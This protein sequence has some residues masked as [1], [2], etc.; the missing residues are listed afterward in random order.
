MTPRPVALGLAL[1]DH[2]IVERGTDKV[3]LIGQFSTIRLAAFPGVPLPF[4][5][6]CSLTGSAG[7]GTVRLEVVE[8]ESLAI[9]QEIDRPI[10]LRDRL[11]E[12][13][14]I[15]R[16]SECR[17]PH[18]GSYDFQLLVDGEWIAQ[19]R[20]RVIEGLKGETA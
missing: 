12:L 9:V 10:R 5:V 11:E 13:R 14:R 20:I 19:R 18:P 16:L 1:C 4:C 15:F 3:S 2:V 8:L 7:D 6:Y 17:F